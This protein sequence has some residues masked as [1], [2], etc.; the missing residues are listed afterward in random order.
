M[1]VKEI[2]RAITEL[3]PVELAELAAWIENYQAQQWDKQIEED[4][5]AGR[6]DALLKQVDKE[7]EAGLSEPL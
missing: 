3:S 6:L 4:L 5:E 1:G 7:Y 2:E